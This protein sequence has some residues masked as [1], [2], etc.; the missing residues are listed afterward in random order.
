MEIRNNI[1]E[2]LLPIAP[3]IVDIRNKQ[4][5]SVP[6]TYFSELS[7]EVLFRINC[8]TLFIKDTNKTNAYLVPNNYFS[9][10]SDNIIQIINT[11][12][13]HF[14][15]IEQELSNVAPLLNTIKKNNVYALP[16]NY[17][18]S[19]NKPSQSQSSPIKPII[20]SKRKWFFYVAAAAFTGLV[21]LG[22][23]NFMSN[24]S[25]K[26]NINTELAKTN[27]DEL[28]DFLDNQTTPIFFSQQTDEDI[29]G[30]FE[31]T[32]TED[33]IYYLKEQPQKDESYIE[34]I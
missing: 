20:N 27:E 3:S 29:F 17:F 13:R 2:E 23:F 10:L 15:E 21:L 34:G 32:E 19:K 18:E 26:L 6:Y 16:E 1:K 8:S 5:Y 30:I 33:L 28:T 22:V 14:S 4:T 12:N 25:N 11:Q 9:T 31:G 24:S 7:E